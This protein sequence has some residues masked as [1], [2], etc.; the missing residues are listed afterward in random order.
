MEAM[1]QRLI[2]YQNKK[3]FNTKPATDAGAG[4]PVRTAAGDEPIGTGT[5][6]KR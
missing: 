6:R 4:S 5:K 3:G 1:K 2:A